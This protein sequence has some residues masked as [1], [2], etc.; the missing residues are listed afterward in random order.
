MMTKS[1]VKVPMAIAC[2]LIF[3]LVT[4]ALFPAF[5]GDVQVVVN[6]KVG[7]D[8][9][10][11]N[12]LRDIFLGKK[13]TLGNGEAIAFVILKE[14]DTHV[15][16]LKTYIGK[17][18]SQFNRYWKKQVFTGKGKMPKS[19]SSESSLVEYVV[20]NAGTIGYVSKG[21]DVSSVKVISVN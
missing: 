15:T 18:N 10:D 12:T 1:L 17:T 13:T 16:F 6:K 11:A 4:A 14:G 9:V 7:V 3:G 5:A 19:F 21:T 2:L 8:A 20:G